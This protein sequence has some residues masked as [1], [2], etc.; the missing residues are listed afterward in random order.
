MNGDCKVCGALWR[1]SPLSA[2]RPECPT[3]GEGVC[4]RC[5]SIRC[6]GCNTHV[7]LACAE[8]YGEEEYCPVCAQ[9]AVTRDLVAADAWA[10]NRLSLEE[11]L[12]ASIAIAQHRK[13]MVA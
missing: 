6:F 7:H 2:P 4:P 5:E 10:A 3:C 11:K 12:V 1:R 13:A 8:H 9:Q